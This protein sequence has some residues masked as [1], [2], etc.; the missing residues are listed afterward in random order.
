MRASTGLV[1]RGRKTS[2]SN[3]ALSLPPLPWP[4]TTRSRTLKGV[5]QVNDGVSW[6]SLAG[7]PSVLVVCGASTLGRNHRR[8]KRRHRR[9]ARTERRAIDWFLES[10]QDQ[11]A[12]ALLGFFGRHILH[13]EDAFSVKRGVL[14]SQPVTALVDRSNAAP[15][16]SG[17][18]KHFAQDALR[19][20]VS[21]VT[22]RAH[23]LI[24][25]LGAPLL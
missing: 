10:L 17:H 15:L 19:G 22:N 7:M 9:T 11:R 21:F 25:S 3:S 4:S 12:D 6:V 13:S 5:G 14:F 1:N 18:L 20:K 23:V 16:P 8:S 2:R 24:L